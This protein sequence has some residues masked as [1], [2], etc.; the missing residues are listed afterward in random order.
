M[1]GARPA[2]PPLHVHALPDHLLV[3][4]LYHLDVPES[5]RAVPLVCRRWAHLATTTP[6]LLSSLSA[7]IG[8]MHALSKLQALEQAAGAGALA[9]QARRPGVAPM[10][11]LPAG[12]AVLCSSLQELHVEL[13]GDI[14]LP[15]GDWTAALPRLRSLHLSSE[16]EVPLLSRTLGCLTALEGL[17]LQ[18]MLTVAAAATLPAS[19]TRLH[20]GELQGVVLPPQIGRLTRLHSLSISA[21]SIAGSGYDVLRALPSLQRLALLSNRYLP[22][23]LSRLTQLQALHLEQTP[24]QADSTLA[25]WDEALSPLT[26]LT[27][28]EMCPFPHKREVML[29]LPA[30][31]TRLCRLQRFAYHGCQFHGS[32]EFADLMLPGGAWLAGLRCLWLPAAIFK[33]SWHL[34]EATPRLEVLGVCCTEDAGSID[35]VDL[36][37]DGEA[38]RAALR[39]AA[40]HPAVRRLCLEV[41][42]GRGSVS[43]A[44]ACA[45]FDGTLAALRRKP[46]L[47]V[48]RG[49]G[50]LE[51]LLAPP[52]LRPR[53]LPR[54]AATSRRRRRNQ[55]RAVA[56]ASRAR[57][58]AFHARFIKMVA[59]AAVCQAQA[60]GAATAQ[61]RSR[62]VRVAA[63]QQ[64]EAAPVAAPL[65]FLA[66]GL[67]A[68]AVATCGSPAEAGVVLVQPEVKN[69]VNN[70]APAPKAAKA[71]NGAAPA[72]KEAASKKAEESGAPG[73]A[74][75]SIRPLAL[76]LALLA[77]GGAGFAASKAD[78]EFAE[79]MAGEWSL[80][81]S[82]NY[83]GYETAPGLKDTPFFGGSNTAGAKPAA[84]AKTQKGGT[85]SKKA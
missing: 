85:T 32:K 12:P 68:A 14:S 11:L 35:D 78:P 54:Q 62:V 28:L 51:G 40:A 76:P 61:R 74:F 46:A 58:L 56:C 47:A 2:T 65:R 49:R 37:L 64:Q 23:S 75:E 69:F 80:K 70:T 43:P 5:F 31:L 26:Q 27:H 60:F 83:A 21:A 34:L 84:K 19:L 8:G 15:L 81:D 33:A 30:A 29:H 82:S 79:L 53:R 16:R 59:T 10:A 52:E 3:G 39:C 17:Q 73:G 6:Q 50:V 44:A 71:A 36:P 22:A 66:A 7:R 1:A 45:L 77:V 63:V 48:E 18:G 24:M 13:R 55:L 20:L 4:M 67:A 57:N 25:A 9:E 41:G 38:A 42:E 72:K